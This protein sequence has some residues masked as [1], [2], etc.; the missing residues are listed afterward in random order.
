MRV[1]SRLDPPD[2]A[3]IEALVQTGWSKA[4]AARRLGIARQRLYERLASIR[5]R[6]GLDTD[7]PQIRIELALELWAVRMGEL[8]GG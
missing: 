5:A 4:A 2:L 1:P 3:T 6:H 7:V 8:A